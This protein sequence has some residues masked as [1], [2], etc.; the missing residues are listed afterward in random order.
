MRAAIVVLGVALAG[1]GLATLWYYV[2]W[3]IPLLLVL[4][5]CLAGWLLFRRGLKKVVQKP[6]AAL[7]LM[8]VRILL[9]A[10]LAAAGAALVILVEVWLQTQDGWSD[11][12]KQ[13]VTALSAALTT[14]I[15]ALLV[16]GAETFD[17]EWLADPIRDAFQD[18]LSGE[19]PDNSRGQVALHN[20]QGDWGSSDR[21]KRVK[22]I[23]Q[24]LHLP[25]RR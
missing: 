18:R 19:F 5:G 9:P 16:K 13:I 11:E 6:I 10:S 25:R 4:I 15:G 20:L 1:A 7:R 22:I 2:N 21:K 24:Q 8:E 17:E 12:R 3:W 14:F 23:D